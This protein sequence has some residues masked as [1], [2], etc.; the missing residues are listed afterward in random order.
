MEPYAVQQ[1]WQID[2]RSYIQELRTL[3][4][5]TSIRRL[6]GSDARQACRTSPLPDHRIGDKE[7]SSRLAFGTTVG[8]IFHDAA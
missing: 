8:I 6:L 3:P 2:W 1:S 4:S 5:H 7:L